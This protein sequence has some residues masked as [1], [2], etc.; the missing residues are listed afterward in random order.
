MRGESPTCTLSGV[1]GVMD[2]MD[3]SDGEDAE[4]AM[5]MSGSHSPGARCV[6]GLWVCCVHDLSS[7]S[8]KRSWSFRAMC[9][10][11]TSDG[12]GS[13]SSNTGADRVS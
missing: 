3:E 1:D 5:S 10:F 4:K 13:G 9:G 7:S 6:L 2:D 8:L 11:L 12:R